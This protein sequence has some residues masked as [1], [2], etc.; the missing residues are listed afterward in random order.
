MVIGATQQF[1]AVGKDAYGNVVAFTP[2]WSVEA[3]GG[4]IGVGG[5]QFGAI[6]RASGWRNFVFD[7]LAL[8][9]GYHP[10][11]HRWTSGAARSRTPGLWRSPHGNSVGK[12]TTPRHAWRVGAW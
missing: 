2:T 3:S 11:V 9:H 6:Q 4:T 8:V 10:L 12:C 5:K 7:I 1:T